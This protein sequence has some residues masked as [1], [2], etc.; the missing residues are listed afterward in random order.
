MKIP[1]KITGNGVEL[2]PARAEHAE[3]LLE[4]RNAPHKSQFLH[5][6]AITLAQQIAWMQ[7]QDVAQNHIYFISHD[8]A[9]RLPIGTIR[10]YDEKLELNSVSIGSWVMLDRTPAKLGLETLALAVQYIDYLGFT[11]CHFGIHRDNTSVIKFHRN[12]GACISEETSDG[13]VLH[14]SPKNFLHHLTNRYKVALN[15]P[16]CVFE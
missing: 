16:L 1:A 8:K 14:N 5:R 10:I 7:A 11:H 6:G 15:H 2:L 13:L 3:F 9:T 12:L 4:I